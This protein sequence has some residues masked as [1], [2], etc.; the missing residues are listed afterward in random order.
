[1]ADCP[2]EDSVQFTGLRK[3]SCYF[4]SLY[5]NYATMEKW[6]FQGK[7]WILLEG[8]QAMIISVQCREGEALH[9]T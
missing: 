7:Y 2:L 9:D 3:I 8:P 5:K 6:V 1:M 4:E